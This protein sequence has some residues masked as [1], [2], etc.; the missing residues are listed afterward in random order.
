MCRLH[1]HGSPQS[2]PLRMVWSCHPRHPNNDVT[3]H[4]GS[5]NDVRMLAEDIHADIYA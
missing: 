4:V 1:Q 2:H 3:G 5:K